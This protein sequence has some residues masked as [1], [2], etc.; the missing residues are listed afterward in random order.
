MSRH[1]EACWR[2]AEEVAASA[3]PLPKPF[4]FHRAALWGPWHSNQ[5]LQVLQVHAH[6]AHTPDTSRRTPHITYRS[7]ERALDA[8]TIARPSYYTYPR[9]QRKQPLDQSLSLKFSLWLSSLGQ[10]ATALPAHCARAWREYDRSAQSI[11]RNFRSAVRAAAPI[12]TE[13][14][15]WPPRSRHR[16]PSRPSCVCVGRA[17]VRPRRRGVH[18]SSARSR[19]MGWRERAGR[20]GRD[21]GGQGE[22]MSDHMNDLYLRVLSGAPCGG[23][24]ALGA[25]RN[26]GGGGLPRTLARRARDRIARADV[27]RQAHVQRWQPGRGLHLLPPLSIT[28]LDGIG[29]L[30]CACDLLGGPLLFLAVAVEEDRRLGDGLRGGQRDLVLHELEL[31]GAGARGERERAASVRAR[32]ESTRV[33]EGRERGWS[34]GGA[35]VFAGGC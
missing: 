14:Q 2:L 34:E 32:G 28:F 31:H 11:P 26:R 35:S 33:G 5:V 9:A 17:A 20:E 22:H 30:L 27:G 7:T 6:L 15:F 25:G 23:R 21:S 3:P 18:H 19:E 16:P 10:S 12:H 4:S 1:F 29:L 8:C 24:W 13:E